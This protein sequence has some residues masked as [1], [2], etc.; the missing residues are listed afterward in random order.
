[1]HEIVRT[2]ELHLDALLG[3]RI[4][5][6][7]SDMRLA[8]SA[9]SKQDHILPAL[10]ESQACQFVYLRPGSTGG[11]VK[12]IIIQRLDGGKSR[13]TN[14]CLTRTH[15][16]NVILR[17][18]HL[19]QIVQKGPVLAERLGRQRSIMLHQPIKLEALAISI[20][21]FMLQVH[22]C[23]RVRSCSYTDN[24]CCIGSSMSCDQC[25]VVDTGIGAASIDLADHPGMGCKAARSS[26]SSKSAGAFCVTGCMR[27]FATSR[28]HLATS[29][30]A[31]WTSTV[32]PICF[33]RLAS[34]T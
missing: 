15:L 27:L 18:K 24:G 12:V 14:Q 32:I 17:S 3:C 23:T 19:L 6:S 22:G 26:S 30:L 16:T 7:D 10:N 13:H 5:Q 21:P 11:K 31:V 4:A 9:G 29:A 8:H 34:G 25:E 33:S 20:N 28:S 1:Q 2:D